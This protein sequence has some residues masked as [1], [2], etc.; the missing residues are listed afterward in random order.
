MEDN[1]ILGISRAN[2]YS[3]NHIGNDADIFHLTCQAITEIV[4]NVKIVDE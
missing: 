4:M 3:P 1:R 2:I